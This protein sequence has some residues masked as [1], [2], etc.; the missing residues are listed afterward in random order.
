MVEIY[1]WNWDVTLRLGNHI[2]K[3]TSD[4]KL[5]KKKKKK[6]LEVG[7]KCDVGGSRIW[8]QSYEWK[9]LWRIASLLFLI[10]NNDDNGYVAERWDT[11]T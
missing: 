9:H 5:T 1:S 8:L 7:A 6:R 11:K 3:F 2:I 4:K 10:Y